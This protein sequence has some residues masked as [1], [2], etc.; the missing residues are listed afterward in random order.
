[1]NVK[2]LESYEG[3]SL[4]VGEVY[5]VDYETTDSYVFRFNGIRFQALK[6]RFEILREDN[7][8]TFREV[9][10]AIKEGEV[11]ESNRT[12]IELVN[13]NIQISR[14]VGEKF[15]S[16]ILQFSEYTYFTLQRKR[17]KFDE[18]M[19]SY[20]EKIIIESCVTG[21]KYRFDGTTDLICKKGFTEYT[22]LKSIFIEEIKGEWYIYG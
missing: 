20:K 18:A 4:K 11:W 21:D 14:I 1:M 9:I 6:D 13:G 10:A 8:K 22:R 17:Y 16:Y 3:S 12:R 15:D 19:K 7:K 5:T 2:C